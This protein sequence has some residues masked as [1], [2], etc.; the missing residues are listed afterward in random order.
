MTLMFE[1]KNTMD[2]SV[3][4]E[5][6]VLKHGSESAPVQKEPQFGTTGDVIGAKPLTEE[7]VIKSENFF[8]R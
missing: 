5:V 4:C 3:S 2:K 7:L 6:V 8:K 1:W